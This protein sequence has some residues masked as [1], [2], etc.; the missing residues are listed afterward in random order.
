MAN[1]AAALS[2]WQNKPRACRDEIASLIGEHSVLTPEVSRG[3]VVAG[4][5]AEVAAQFSGPVTLGPSSFTELDDVADSFASLDA[6]IPAG[7]VRVKLWTV[8]AAG[9]PVLANGDHDFSW[10]R[11]WVVAGDFNGAPVVDDEFGDP[12]VV[13]HLTALF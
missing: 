7:H 11:E 5:A 9:L 2:R 10:E 12:V 6:P 8:A 13:V 1:T 3:M 4:T